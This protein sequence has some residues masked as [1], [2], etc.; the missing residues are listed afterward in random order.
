M[1]TVIVPANAAEALQMLEAGAG[2]LAD[3][4]AAGMPA[5]AAG[6]Y[7]RGLE[8]AD[9]VQA[10]ARGRFPAA[11]DARGGPAGDGQRTSRSWL[12]HALRVTRGQA[13]AYQ[14]VQAL[15]EEHAPLLAGLRER[16]VTTSVALQLAKW[17]QPIPA[18]F[19]AQAEEILIAAA[20]AGAGLRELAAICAEIR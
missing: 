16:A 2:F 10:V 8:R 12:V 14:A 20:R 15:A 5:E 1:S 3:L 7:L 11:F 17:T 9:A 19:R 18:Q 6:G 4:D 13:G